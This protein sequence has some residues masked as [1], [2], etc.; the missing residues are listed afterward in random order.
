MAT[1]NLAEKYSPKVA[2][3]FAHK[4]YSAGIASDA[5][6]FDGVKTIKVYS[7]DTVPLGN[8]SKAVN[9]FTG[10]RYG[11]PTD[12]TDSFQTMTLEQ[13]K[14]FT[15]II[16]KG[17]DKNQLN[18]KKANRALA[19][20]IDE[21]VHPYMDKYNFSKWAGCAGQSVIASA[22]ITSQTALS[23]IQDATELLDEEACPDSG[24]TLVVT[25]A[26]HK[27]LKQNPNFV[28]TDKLATD[29]MVRGKVGEMDGMTIRKVPTSYMPA[30][31]VAFACH[32]SAL[33]APMKL[34]EYKIHVDPPGINGNLV[35]GRIMHDAF[36]LDAKAN[37]VV[38]ICASTVVKP[39]VVS[40]IAS[41]K[42]SITITTADYVLY[43]LDGT[44]PRCSGTAVKSTSSVSNVATAAGDVLKVVAVKENNGGLQYLRLP[45]VVDA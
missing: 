7:V 4:A 27:I 18:I 14:T 11:T 2:E 17:D 26:F 45:D 28:Y 6:D 38:A 43:T 40:A 35:E 30:G 37:A 1:Q 25:N 10:S 16:D 34:Q 23:L 42:A 36:V 21:R 44:D 20:E 15:Y 41:H 22:A 39:A 3:R 29:S 33:L 12:L 13:D 19:R 32:S 9:G 8:Y 5:Y 31:I 24:R